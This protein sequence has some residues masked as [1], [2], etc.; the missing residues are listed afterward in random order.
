MRSMPAPAA[1]LRWVDVGDEV[2]VLDLRSGDLH[3]L[4]RPAAAIWHRLDGGATVDDVSRDLAARFDTDPSRMRPEVEELLTRLRSL[5]LLAQ[6]ATPRLP[7]REQSESP[8]P[9]P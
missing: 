6:E 1:A 4:D 9:L 7:S 2:V 8:D 5:H 3:L